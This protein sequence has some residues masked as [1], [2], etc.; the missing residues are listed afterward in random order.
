VATNLLFHQQE[1][2]PMDAGIKTA[3]CTEYER[4]LKESHHALS[5]YNEHLEWDDELHNLQEKYDQAYG[6]LRSHARDCEFC[7]FVSRMQLRP[8]A[9]KTTDS[10]EPN[11]FMHV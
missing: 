6:R 8:A 4:L 9:L 3:V 11:R 1:E 5:E 10:L 2:T 7:Q